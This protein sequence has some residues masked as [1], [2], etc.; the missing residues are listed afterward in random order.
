MT[1]HKWVYDFAEGS[2]DMRE[3]LGGKGA[4]VAEMTRV[5]GAGPNAPPSG[6]ADHHPIVPAGFTITTEACVAYMRSGS[7]PEELE[8]QVAAA[9]SRLEEAAGKRFGDAADPLLVSVR[10]GAR[11]SMPGML[12]TIL[13]VGLND[14][15]VLGLARVTDNER[16]AWD[17]YRRLVQMFGNVVEGVP[18]SRFE[19]ALAAAKREAAVE[20]DSEI[21]ADALRRLVEEF[22]GLYDFPQDPQEQLRR[23]IRA[24]FDS[25]MGE[26]AVQYRRISRIPDDWGT[27][28]NVQQMVFGNKGDDSAT[29]VAFSRDEVTGAPEPSGDFL[30]NAQGEDVVSGVRTPRDISELAEVMPEAH[31]QLMEIMR[32]LESEYKDMQ[33]VEFTV[34]SGRLYMLQTRS[35]KRPAQAAVRFAVDAV[36]E[37]LLTREEALA[38]IDAYAL[39][40]LLHPTFDRSDG[41]DVIARGVAAS[42]GAAAG[43]IVF[44]A[45]DAVAQAAAGKDVILVRPFTEADDVAGFHAARGILTSEGG[46]ASHAALVARG[47]GVPAVT[48]AAVAIDLNAGELTI[49]GRVFKA[50]ERIAIDGSEGAVVEPG[51]RLIQPEIDENFDRVLEW[52]DEVRRLGVR[53][54]ADTPKDAV[55]ARELG[56]E[57]IGLCRTEHMF[58]AEDRQPKMRAMIMA[59]DREGRRAALGELLPLQR[60]DFVGI[61]D[62]MRGLPVTIRLLDPPLHEFLPNLP[63]L[64]AHLERA[65]IE[66]TDDL[67][68]L[69]ELL[70]R[71]EEI[72]EGNPMLGTRG[73]RL[74]ILY[75]EIYEMQVHAIMQAAKAVD[76]PPCP[77]IM[78]PLVAYEHEL[79][80]ARELVVSVGEEY[81]MREREDYTVGTMIEL[82][83]ACFIANR[84]ARH[85]DFFSFGTNDLTQTALGFSRDDVESKFIPAYIEDKIIDRSPFETID[86]PG[87][88]WLV[89][90]AAWVGREAHPGLKLGICGEHGGDPDSIAFFHMAGLDYVS[91]SPFRVPIARIA[92]AQATIAPLSPE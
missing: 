38:T 69:E 53:V 67:D 8:G 90:L 77:E 28:V 40:A 24:V 1:D 36:G 66:V 58:M 32:T 57:G 21:S 13:N 55:R 42:P 89:R 20:T 6:A 62:A 49:D 2:K 15:S 29:G 79:E 82:P 78:I 68:E 51:A 23:A 43:E 45:A 46:K 86:S 26:R 22:K 27:A 74:G 76:E 56:A 50:G 30:V 84:I 64:R 19:D 83:R 12:D 4:N 10:S 5:L 39:D 85:A 48:G 72:H 70:A 17:S 35:A 59:D 18:G 31:A 44:T 60:E 47:M 61:F 11:E 73:V 9:L 41:Y 52:A 71:V 54:N 14:A 91:C 16:F 80:I 81:G 25:W 34:E 75:P 3:L 92:A 88:G 37:G 87:V 63:E 33:D 65:R 7:E